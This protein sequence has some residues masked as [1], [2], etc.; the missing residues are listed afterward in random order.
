MKNI[1]Y[2]FICGAGSKLLDDI[3]DIYGKENINSYVLEILKNG[4][5]ILLWVVLQSSNYFIAW[6]YFF[7][8][9]L[10]LYYPKHIP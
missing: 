7:V 9:Y 4:F 2:G 10:L 5:I 3:F 6:Y 1:L 8:F